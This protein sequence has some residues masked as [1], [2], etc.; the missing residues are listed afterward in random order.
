MLLKKVYLCIM[1]YVRDVLSEDWSEIPL[2][3]F[4]RAMLGEVRE[5]NRFLLL[6][7]L[8]F[9]SKTVLRMEFEGLLGNLRGDSHCIRDE[10]QQVAG[11]TAWITLIQVCRCKRLVAGLRHLSRRPVQPQW[12]LAL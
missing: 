10:L 1:E 11:I 6:L 8:A 4:S 5:L 2:P 3:D 12:M 9:T 7:A